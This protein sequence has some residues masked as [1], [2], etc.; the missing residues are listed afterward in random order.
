[1]VIV[2]SPTAVAITRNGNEDL[3]RTRLPTG[4]LNGDCGSIWRSEFNSLQ[5]QKEAHIDTDNVATL[6]RKT[7]CSRDKLLSPLSVRLRAAAERKTHDF[8]IKRNVSTG[9]P[10]QPVN[11]PG[12]PVIDWLKQC[13]T[14]KVDVEFSIAGNEA[15]DKI[16]QISK[17]YLESPY[18]PGPCRS[19]W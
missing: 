5:N 17:P 1:M 18:R 16:T 4:P 19:S 14:I 3:Y 11:L 9:Q 15:N 2:I 7:S 10:L 12:E 6:S 8:E 13:P